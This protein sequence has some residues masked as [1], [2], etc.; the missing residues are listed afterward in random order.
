[1]HEVINMNPLN[2]FGIQK[3]FIRGDTKSYNFRCRQCGNKLTD[4][5]WEELNPNM[6]CPE[7]GQK[8]WK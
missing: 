8:G 4:K 2:H 1:M 6:R 7:C 3:K 5:D